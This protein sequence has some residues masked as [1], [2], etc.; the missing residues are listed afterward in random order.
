MRDIRHSKMTLKSLKLLQNIS[1]GEPN[2]SFETL[3]FLPTFK[4]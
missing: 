3:F 2:K 1:I 4:K